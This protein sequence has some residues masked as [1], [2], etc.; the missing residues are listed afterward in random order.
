MTYRLYDYNRERSRGK[1]DLK[2]GCTAIMTPRPGLPNLEPKMDIECEKPE[3]ITEF[4]S[5]C[6]IKATGDRIAVKSAS[7]MHLVTATKGSCIIS[8]P[9]ENWNLELGS[10]FTCL[11]PATVEG[12]TIDTCGSGEALIAPLKQ[13]NK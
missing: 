8:G 7:H 9:T 4:P 3:L 1:L 12:Y 10:S 11:V 13:M 5:F 2:D 6:V